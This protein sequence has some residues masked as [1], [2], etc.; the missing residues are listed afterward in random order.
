MGKS[1]AGLDSEDTIREYGVALSDN[2][3]LEA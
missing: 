1:V 3:I 2:D